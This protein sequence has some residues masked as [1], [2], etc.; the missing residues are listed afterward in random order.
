MVSIPRANAVERKIYFFRANVGTDPSG[1][2]LPFDPQPDLDFIGNL[3]FSDEP[4]GRYLSEG[5]ESVLF[6]L[7]HGGSSNPRVQFS[8]VRRAGLPQLE[9]AGNV[10]DLDIAPDEGLLE[11]THAVFFPG[12]VVGA[13]YNH[14]GPRISLLGQYLHKL[15]DCGGPMA[16]FSPILRDDPT[17]QLDRLTDI[18]VFDIAVR[19]PYIDSVKQASSSLADTLEATAGLFE[20]PERIQLV[21]KYPAARRRSAWDFF[22]NPLRSL[23]TFNS[24]SP[25]IDRLQVRGHCEDIDRVEGLDLLKDNIIATKQVVRL[26]GRGRA[27]DPE[28]AFQAIYESYRQFA[29]EITDGLDAF[30]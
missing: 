30:L 28:S 9:R 6:L 29:S 1:K 18:R 27:I 20:E 4:D 26:G 23:V 5:D 15:S 24:Q 14:Y 11:T 8:R 21:L 12:N 7:G 16:T 13:E 3:P 22:R 10:S 17:R 19:R 2:P 25:V